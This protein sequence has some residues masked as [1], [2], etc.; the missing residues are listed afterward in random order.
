MSRTQGQTNNKNTE[1]KEHWDMQH[2]TMSSTLYWAFQWAIADSRREPLVEDAK[3]DS[4]LCISI[5]C[6]TLL[7]FNYYWSFYY[8]CYNPLSK[9][10]PTIC[11]TLEIAQTQHDVRMSI[12]IN[13]YC[14]TAGEIYL[15]PRTQNIYDAMSCKTRKESAQEM[16]SSTSLLCTRYYSQTR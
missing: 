16:T 8:L 7:F 10:K 4:T 13:C 14:T 5:K 1:F 3:W 15:A 11:Y 9:H 12:S 6:V 2:Y